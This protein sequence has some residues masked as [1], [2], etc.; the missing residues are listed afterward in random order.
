MLLTYIF[1]VTCNSRIT[2]NYQTT[3][4]QCRKTKHTKKREEWKN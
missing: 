4:K 2:K 1:T 3:I